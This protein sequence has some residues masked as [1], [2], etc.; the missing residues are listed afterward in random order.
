M[1]RQVGADPSLAAVGV[2]YARWIQRRFPRGRFGAI[3]FTLTGAQ[4]GWQLFV[5]A[6]LVLALRPSWEFAV[7]VCAL[8]LIVWTISGWL[9]HRYVAKAER[10]N[11]AY[12]ETYQNPP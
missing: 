11:R 1:G 6:A 10:T 12:L 9:I 7:E 4:F 2:A 5:I 8:S 3:R